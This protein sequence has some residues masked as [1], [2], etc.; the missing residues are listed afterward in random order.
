MRRIGL[1]A[2]A[3]LL[4]IFGGMAFFV[5]SNIP[6]LR[7]IGIGACLFSVFLIR[8]PNTRGISAPSVNETGFETNKSANRTLRLTSLALVARL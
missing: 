1:L 8:M 4:L 5:G 7:A 3:A 2:I 6:G